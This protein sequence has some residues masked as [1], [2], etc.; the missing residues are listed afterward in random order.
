MAEEEVFKRFSVRSTFIVK[1]NQDFFPMKALRAVLDARHGDRPAGHWK[2]VS[3]F[4]STCGSTEVSL[5]KYE[6]KFEA[7]SGATSFK[8]INRPEL[9]YFLYEFLPLIDEHNK[10]PQN[11]LALEKVWLTK[12]VWFRNI[13]SLLGQCTFDMHGCFRNR[14]IEKGVAPSTVDSIRVL[15]FADLM[16]GCLKKWPRPRQQ[17]RVFRNENGTGCG[18]LARIC[19]RDGGTTK[20]PSKQQEQQGRKVGYSYVRNCF[21]FRGYLSK[22]GMKINNQTSFWCSKCQMPLYRTDRCYDEEFGPPGS[23]ALSCVDAHYYADNNSVIC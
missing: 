2:G 4:L 12:D 10:L 3:F 8:L 14:M 6:S 21:V 23:R 20:P 17:F 22:K 13:I 7:A 11:L 9:A 16:Y 18:R 1:N 15:K 5:V 19:G